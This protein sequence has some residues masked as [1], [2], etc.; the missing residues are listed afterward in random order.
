MGWSRALDLRDQ[1]NEGHTQ[2]VTETTVR[3]ARAMGVDEA[4]IGP[5]SPRCAPARHRKNGVPDYI[6]HKPEELTPEEQE[7]M[8]RIPSL[9]TTCSSHCLTHPR[10]IFPTVTM[11][12]GWHGLPAALKGEA[13]PLAARIFRRRRRLDALHSDPALPAGWPGEK[14]LE[15][16]RG[17]SGTISTPGG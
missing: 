6:L 16:I 5:H 3:L 1:E 2:R 7:I 4:Q 12:N 17:L 14:V 13:I 11:K 9:P 15:H 8:R 10:W